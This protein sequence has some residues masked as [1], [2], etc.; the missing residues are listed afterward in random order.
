V[1][2]C[3]TV[4]SESIQAGQSPVVDCAFKVTTPSGEANNADMLVTN[5]MANI[6]LVS[7]EC[8]VIANELK[9]CET[10]W[11][12]N[13]IIDLAVPKFVDIKTAG[14]NASVSP[15]ADSGSE[16]NVAKSD[17][18][19]QL[20][21]TQVGNVQLRGILGAPSNAKL[22]Q[23]NPQL[24]DGGD[25]YIPIYCAVCDDVNEDLILTAQVVDQ[26]QDCYYHKLISTECNTILQDDVEISDEE[27]FN[28]ISR[29]TLPVKSCDAADSV[30]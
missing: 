11:R 12:S 14:L 18:L 1:N 22:V 27:E 25:Q 6:E 19:A 16:I 24:A 28:N 10:G 2:H 23:L 3:L 21:S 4:N 13:N 17:V 30:T 8:V 20:D 15:L 9:D 5:A 7:C 26:L 29:D